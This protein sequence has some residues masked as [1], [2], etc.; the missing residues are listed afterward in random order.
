MAKEKVSLPVSYIIEEK[1]GRGKK[2]LGTG[3]LKP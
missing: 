3:L 1:E 2:M